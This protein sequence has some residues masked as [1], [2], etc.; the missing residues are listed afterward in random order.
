MANTNKGIALITLAIIIAFVAISSLGIA[1][2]VFNRLQVSAV[3]LSQIRTIYL[4]QAGI[5][6][7][8]YDYRNEGAWQEME[9]NISGIQYFRI[10]ENGSFALVDTREDDLIGNNTMLRN[11]K[12]GNVH[13]ANPITITHITVSWSPNISSERIEKIR[14]NNKTKWTGSETS[15]T[16]IDIT[17]TTINVGDEIDNNRFEFNSDMS[18]KTIT[19]IFR[20]SDNSARSAVLYPANRKEFSIKSTG[21][22]QDGQTWKRTLEATYDV[23]N[24][25]ITSW[26]ETFNHL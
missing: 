13:K 6:R 22:I 18:G 2:F 16:Q 4:A 15:G 11:W 9:V 21:K 8:I 7:A 10:G 12:V 5:Y 14:I 1:S 24:S 23:V 25:K 17:D 20:F 19:A 26:K 3:N